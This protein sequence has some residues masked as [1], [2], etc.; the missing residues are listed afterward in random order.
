MQSSLQGLG[1]SR[2]AL[3]RVLGRAVAIRRQMRPDVPQPG[4]KDRLGASLR[5]HCKSDTAH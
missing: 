5:S 3:S 4:L 2:L 1:E